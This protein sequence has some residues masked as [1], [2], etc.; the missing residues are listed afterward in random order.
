MKR[1]T[2]LFLLTITISTRAVTP[3]EWFPLT[4]GAIDPSTNAVYSTSVGSTNTGVFAGT[5]TAGLPVWESTNVPPVPAPG[6]TVAVYFD[7]TG[8]SSK[9]SINT[10]FRGI[11]GTNARTVTAWI[12]AQPSQPSTGG[13]HFI[14][15]GGG[16]A[17]SITAGRYSI[18]LQPDTAGADAGKLRLEIQ[19]GGI[20]GTKD[21]RDGKW[22]HIAVL[23]TNGSTVGNAKLF[24]DGNVEPITTSSGTTLVINTQD[25]T[26]NTQY[27]TD[28]VRIGNAGWDAS[29]GFNGAIADVRFYTNALSQS[30]ILAIIYGAGNPPAITQQPANQSSLLGDTNAVVT[31]TASVSGSP[32]LNYQ[33]KHAGTN[34]IGQTNISLLIGPGISAANLGAYQIAVSNNWGSVVS[35]NVNLV[36]GTATINPPVQAVLVGASASLSV[37]TPSGISGYTFQWRENGTNIPGATSSTLQ[38]SGA[39][40]ANDSTNYTV[41]ETLAGNSATSAPPAVIRVLSA[42]ASVY[43]QEILLDGPAAYWRLDEPNGATV[44][45]DQTTFHNGLF[46]NYNGSQLEQPSG[47]ASDTN[48]SSS[49]SSGNFIDVPFSTELARTNGYSLEAWVNPGSIGARADILASFGGLPNAGY[50]LAIN[51]AGNFVFRTSTNTSS[52]STSWNDLTAGTAL[53]GQWTHLVATYDGQTKR[54]Y[55][56][57]VL[58]ASATESNFRAAAG[59]DILIGAGGTLVAPVNPFNGL[60]D[61]P[62]IYRKT[63]TANQVLNHYLAGSVPAGTPPSIVSQPKDAQVILGDTNASATFTVQVTGS[64]N[65]SFQ[66]FSNSIAI[67]G[68]TNSTIPSRVPALRRRL[69]TMLRLPTV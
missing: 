62:A 45:A 40:F 67:N 15:W 28:L 2:S 54:L 39:T 55:T 21:L 43:A 64:P 59:I 53:A 9:P 61:E 49:F 35:S 46:T 12:K 24:V 48:D 57:G 34:L 7:A 8:S 44:A 13:A 47:L 6:T 60:I 14:N 27:G 42:P 5:G 38:I 25:N 4:E 29:R 17:N 18:K 66:W 23:N 58:A 36:W 63:L 65:F 52:A 20:N 31:F 26:T 1:L 16:S 3:V 30:D 50:E 68:A 51:N 32:A 37:T 22:H 69:F 56:N 10:S 41:I 11:L 19:G 33:W